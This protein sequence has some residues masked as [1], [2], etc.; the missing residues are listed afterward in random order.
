LYISTIIL[1]LLSLN[2]SRTLIH[3]IIL[4]CQEKFDSHRI[5]AG[6]PGFASK[7][8]GIFISLSG[9]SYGDTWRCGFARL[10]DVLVARDA[11]CG[12][13]WTGGGDGS[14]LTTGSITFFRG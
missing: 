12:F 5:Q 8:S 6:V 3:R 1:Y 2:K 13:F 14:F 10:P 9:A 11:G 7:S 4:V